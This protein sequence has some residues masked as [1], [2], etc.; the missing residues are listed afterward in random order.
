MFTTQSETNESEMREAPS[1][2]DLLWER[3]DGRE[4][5]RDGGMLGG[6]ERGIEV[7]GCLG[8]GGGLRER[9]AVMEG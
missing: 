6:G 4:G 8:V 5:R 2:S 3:C 7:M 1:H 9:E